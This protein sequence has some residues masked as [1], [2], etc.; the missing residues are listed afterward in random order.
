MTTSSS[1]R[2]REALAAYEL[3]LCRI[4]NAL[5]EHDFHLV[6]EFRKSIDDLILA[7]LKADRE[8]EVS[9]R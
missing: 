2:Y 1:V 7:M 4:S 9:Q 5:L 8:A 6:P 3:A